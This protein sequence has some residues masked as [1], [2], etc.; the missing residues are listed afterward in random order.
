MSSVYAYFNIS[1]FY[2]AM[3]YN[4]TYCCQHFNADGQVSIIMK[5]DEQCKDANRKTDRHKS[6]YNG[7]MRCEAIKIN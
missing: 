7:C 1:V 4:I 3:F 5:I 6:H 2:Y